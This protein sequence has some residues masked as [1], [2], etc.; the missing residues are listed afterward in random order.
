M[1]LGHIVSKDGIQPDP[2]KIGRLLAISTPTSATE[3][4]SFIGLASY[5]RKFIPNLSG[6]SK[7]LF[8]LTKKHVDFVWTSECDHA[9]NSIKQL[10]TTAPVLALPDFNRSFKIHC[11]ASNYSIGAVISQQFDE[12]EKPIAY[13]SRILNSS[14]INYST[15]E[16]ELLA[17]VWSSKHFKQYIY[18]RDIEFYTDHKPLAVLNKLSEPDGK[19]GK[20]LL[21]IQHLNYIIK[22]KQGKLNTNADALSRLKCNAI[23][24]VSHFDWRVE[25]KLD[26]QLEEIYNR[27]ARQQQPTFVLD[28]DYGKM[29]DKMFVKDEIIYYKY[30]DQDLIVVPEHLKKSILTETHDKPLSGHLGSIRTLARIKQ[31]FIWPNINKEVK[32][33]VQCCDICQHRCVCGRYSKCYRQYR[34]Q[35]YFR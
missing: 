29:L 35:L 33:Y 25:Q 11:D 18:G 13:A 15:S 23:R 10:L 31:Q 16:K 9:F 27:L 3:I 30:Q 24:L 1:F 26:L 8:D 28:K 6:I 7:P 17:I 19:L 32:H 22:Y 12:G 2:A 34:W 20:L 4:R 21:K 14:E 5:Y